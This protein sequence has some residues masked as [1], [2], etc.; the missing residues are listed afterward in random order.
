LA[1]AFDSG[2]GRGAFY[3]AAGAALKPANHVIVP[4]RV[5]ARQRTAQKPPYGR[6]IRMAFC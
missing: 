4:A 3:F 5:R 2:G 1:F 6:Q